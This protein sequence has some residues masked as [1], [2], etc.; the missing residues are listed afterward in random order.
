MIIGGELHY[1]RVKKEEWKDRIKK[2]KEAG[3]N[4]VSTYIPWIVHEK[5]ENNFD[6]EGNKN[7]KEFLSLIREE[8]LF[9]LVR[10]GPYVM[11]ELK[12]EGLPHWIYEKYH[13][14]VAKDID[15]N[16]HPTRVVSLLNPTF[17]NLVEKWYSVI[18]NEIKEFI[19]DGT[20]IMFQLDNEVGM[21]NW[22]TNQPDFS[23]F[24]INMFKEYIG[25]DKDVQIN[26]K[27]DMVIQNKFMDFMR[28]YYKKYFEK[29]ISFT[30]N[31]KVPF[32]I[33]V[34]GFT[35]HDYAKR[36]N[37]YPIGLS[38]L[39]ESLKIENVLTAGDYYIGNPVPENYTDLIIS[40]LFTEVMQNKEQPLFSAEFQSGSIFSYPKLQPTSH[41][42]N[43]RICFS[44]GM[45][46]INYY[47]FVGGEHFEDDI[48]IFNKY[49]DWQAPIGPN[50]ETRIS[51]D[52]I[53]NTIKVLK[54]LETEILNST[55]EYDVIFGIYPD[56]FKTE[57]NYN[58]EIVN[59]IKKQRNS[60]LYYGFLRGILLNNY[61]V[62]GINLLNDE[63][64]T[65][66][67][68]VFS[69]KYM[70]EETQ[71]K[72]VKYL[73]NGGKLLLYP[74][75]PEYD[76]Y[77][78]KCSILK[79]FLEVSI[80]KEYTYDFVKI[81]DINS[82]ATNNTQVFDGDFK[83]LGTS[84]KNDVVAFEKNK[85]N[86][87]VLVLGINFDMQYNHHIEL[88]DKLLKFFGIKKIIQTKD[89]DVRL[90]RIN[91]GYLIFLHNLDD[92]IKDIDIIIN[93]SKIFDG[94][95]IKINARSSLLL[96]YKLHLND[97]L[98]LIYSTC[99]I[100]NKNTNEITFL[101][102]QDEEYIKFN[103]EIYCENNDIDFKDGVYKICGYKNKEIKFK[104]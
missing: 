72:L 52:Y 44:T 21:L 70:A 10:P 6:F 13:E 85:R 45:K 75:I 87:N 23:K 57:F 98:E 83:V 42:L 25:V 76:M 92:Y 79:D 18:L 96:P 48:W 55:Q 2:I 43:T 66:K 36:G 95:K 104:Y 22:V 9:C 12:N 47:M 84:G 34:H 19:E 88:V 8:E 11:S 30:N 94:K 32:V 41:D 39:N 14:V 61:Q 49:H 102:K 81:M 63:I 29:L 31:I 68:I 62:K 53:K 35:T 93:N 5:T 59:H 1:F 16:I 69:T 15:G 33:N 4:L 40:N 20:I 65:D 58:N 71:I 103:K 37:E 7:I 82:I 89:V 60:A 56:Y 80:I 50:G 73:K 90:K 67:L 24:T 17:L 28:I 46:C 91:N 26:F 51:Y 97:K 3:F 64:N 100:V 101:C 74:E 27:E 86:G 78:N 77:G 99:E 54:A 38:Q